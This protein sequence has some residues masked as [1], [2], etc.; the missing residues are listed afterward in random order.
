MFRGPNDITSKR[1]AGVADSEG[2]TS[3]YDHF[4]RGYIQ[5]DL[6]AYL[7]VDVQLDLAYLPVDVLE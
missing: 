4:K 1:D 5:L 7:P 6:V 3:H 2:R